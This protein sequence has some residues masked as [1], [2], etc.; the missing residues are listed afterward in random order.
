MLIS[1]RIN[2]ADDNGE[3][4]FKYMVN[5]H[6]NINT[7]FVLSKDS[8]DYSRLKKIG[9]VLDPNSNKYKLLF[10]ISDYIVSSHAENYIFAPLGNS[11]KFVHDQYYF[12]YIFLQH[13]ITKDDLS[14]WININTK[15]MDMFVTAAK[16][17][18]NS[19]LEYI[20]N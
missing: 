13:G 6:K 19:I 12:K 16:P 3:H 2:K 7:Y 11:S 15:K 9:K 4:F 17:E 1:D 10:Q 18:Y 14:P 8:A 20:N 5:N